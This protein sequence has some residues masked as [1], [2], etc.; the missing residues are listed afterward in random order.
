MEDLMNTKFSTI[1][2]IVFAVAGLTMSGCAKKG[3]DGN[4]MHKGHMNKGQMKKNSDMNNGGRMA[5]NIP[6]DRSVYFAF[7]SSKITANGARI[8]NANAAWLKAHP[9]RS[10]TVEGNCDDRGGREYNLALGQHRADSVKAYLVQHGAPADRISTAS[11]GEENPVCR[12]TGESCWSQNRRAD[13]VI[14]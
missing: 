12:G 8:L 9:Q 11:F 10:A 14:R 13:I 6:A 7:D 1:A 2:I 5:G 4:G 3:I